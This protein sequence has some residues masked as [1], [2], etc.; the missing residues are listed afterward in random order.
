MS[1]RHLQNFFSPG[2]IAMIGASHRDHAVG[3]LLT[4]NLLAAGFAGPILPV[5]PHEGSVGGVLAYKDIA[6]LPLTPGG[7]GVGEAL[8]V[9]LFGMVGARGS[10]GVAVSL[11]FRLSQMLLG[12]LGGVYL[13]LPGARAEIESARQEA[14]PSDD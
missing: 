7:L 10:L 9:W 14:G 3:R 2:S 4:T 8:F 13:L 11:T 1:V 12:L 6:A 5:N